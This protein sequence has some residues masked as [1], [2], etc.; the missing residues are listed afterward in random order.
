MHPDKIR[1]HHP[2]LAGL[3]GALI[4]GLLA[5]CACSG[6]PNKGGPAASKEATGPAAYDCKDHQGRASRRLLEVADAHKSC[7]VDADC[8]TIDLMT[9]CSDNCSTAV[10]QEGVTV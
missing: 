3:R 9:A 5:L 8:A 4:L 6:T 2:S 7:K 1:Q 10:N